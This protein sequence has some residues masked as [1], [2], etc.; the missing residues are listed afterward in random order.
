ME[1]AGKECMTPNLQSSEVKLSGANSGHSLQVHS[2][3]I[4]TDS[5]AHT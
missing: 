4:E 3:Y 2:H 1:L 5:D